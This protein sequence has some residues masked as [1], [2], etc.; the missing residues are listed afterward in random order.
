MSIVSEL[1]LSFEEENETSALSEKLIKEWVERGVAV[2]V[3]KHE[4]VGTI[5]FIR[6]CVGEEV[7][8][9][10][11]QY[12][13]Y[14]T[15]PLDDSSKL[16]IPKD[17]AIKSITYAETHMSQEQRDVLYNNFSMTFNTYI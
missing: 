10:I 12:H 16:I 15:V 3:E 14:L 13:Q 1:L 8:A 11:K 9:D 2:T 6:G 17:C 7:Y 5:S 4:L